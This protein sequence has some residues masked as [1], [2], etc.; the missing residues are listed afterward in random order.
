MKKLIFVCLAVALLLVVSCNQGNEPIYVKPR[1]GVGGGTVGSGVDPGKTASTC[2][3]AFQDLELNVA[4]WNIAWFPKNGAT[5]WNKVQAMI[6]TLD[7]DVIAVQEINS[8]SQFMAL[9]QALQGWGTA[10]V[11]V[12]L[13]Q[14]TGFIYK[15]SAFLQ[16]GT[17]YAVSEL[18]AS[19]PFP[20]EAIRVDAT[21]ASGLE[22]TFIN[23][24]LKCCGSTGGSEYNRRKD[25]SE[26]LEA[27]IEQNL[28]NQAVI[29]LG[30]WNDEI[31]TGEESP[32]DNFKN[33]PANYRF[34]DQAVA[35]GSS[36][37]WSY[38]SWPSHIDHILIT[39]ELFDYLGNVQT[40]KPESC[41]SGYYNDVSD[42]RPVLAS[43][44]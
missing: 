41:V 19:S 44:K 6:P 21:H 40:V 43:F 14:E 10:Y 36:S 8:S 15:E 25:A 38:P 39:D 26:R 23:I 1:K 27:Y 17:P 3:P 5:T 2:Y 22:V 32:F 33:D 20:R 12:R 4:T 24:H 34:A 29:V 16:F 9:G 28:T 18:S 7:A 31:K 13:D 37:N 30:D 42:H 35:D 11:D